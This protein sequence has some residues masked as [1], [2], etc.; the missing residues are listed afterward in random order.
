MHQG[1]V[2]ASMTTLH[3]GGNRRV[4]SRHCPRGRA[5]RKLLHSSRPPMSCRFA[6]LTLQDRPAVVEHLLALDR[7][8]RVLRFNSA[9]PDALIRDYCGRWDFA[10]DIVEGA[11]DGNRLVGVIHLP[12]SPCDGRLIGEFGVSVAE[13]WRRRRVATRL[14]A[15]AIDSAGR[16]GLD[17]I[18]VYFLTRN[19]PML[20]LT[21][22]LAADLEPDGD[23]TVATL[24]L[25][26]RSAGMR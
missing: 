25:D 23:E 8:D 12:V 18:Y 15:R 24:R 6:T 5:P 21:R 1:N 17:R 10:L 14:A 7:D 11:W 4:R 22:R 3:A 13:P 2:A 20:C 9:A 16:R 26:R 19:R